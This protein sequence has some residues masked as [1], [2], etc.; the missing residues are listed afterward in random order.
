MFRLRSILAA[1]AAA[2]VFAASCSDDGGTGPRPGP[3]CIEYASH[4]HAVSGIG[5]AGSARRTAR[6]GDLLFT[7][8]GEAGVLVIDVSDPTAPEIVTTL[9]TPGSAI[10][11]A[12]SDTVSVSP[13]ERT[14]FGS[15]RPG[16]P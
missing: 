12:F 11:L 15:T 6:R 1:L 5:T 7:A 8:A 13:T 14:V 10:D 9:D 2:C 3:G 16:A 4:I